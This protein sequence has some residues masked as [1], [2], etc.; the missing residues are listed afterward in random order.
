MV[1]LKGNF[2]NKGGTMSLIIN[3]TPHTVYL[4]NEDNSIKFAWCPEGEPIRLSQETKRMG[5]LVHNK[6]IDEDEVFIDVPL[7]F[8]KFG[9]TNLPEERDDV[10]Y[11]VSGLVRNAFP[12]RQDLL[13]PNEIV[14]DEEGHILGCR[15][16]SL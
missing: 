12:E 7:T 16:F 4:L 10:Y 6:L 14:R 8:T 5:E 15:S 3:K 2:I 9:S 1:V 13:I 11:I